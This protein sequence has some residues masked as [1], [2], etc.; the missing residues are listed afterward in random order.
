M[1]STSSSPQTN[2]I[3]VVVGQSIGIFRIPPPTP[4]IG[5]AKVW[6]P[7]RREETGAEGKD[8]CKPHE[9]DRHGH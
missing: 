8:M 7:Q 2:E 4:Q 5:V 6:N 9:G 3:Y 1:L